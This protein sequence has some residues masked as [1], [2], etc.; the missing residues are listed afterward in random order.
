MVTRLK[1]PLH[2]TVFALDPASQAALKLTDEISWSFAVLF[3]RYG[4]GQ[5]PLACDN[6]GNMIVTDVSGALA[7]LGGQLK[8]TDTANSPFYHATGS[9][10]SF[11]YNTALALISTNDGKGIADYFDNSDKPEPLWSNGSSLAEILYNLYGLIEDIA[12]GSYAL[13]VIVEP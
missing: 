3:G 1:T 6:A 10:A 5:V 2:Q 4:G 7:E 11:L 8:G 9:I 13:H 12:Y